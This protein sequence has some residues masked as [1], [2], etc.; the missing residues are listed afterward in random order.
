MNKPKPEEYNPYFKPYIQIV[1][2]GNF[3]DLLKQNTLE[4]ADFFKSITA[5]K[6]NFAYMHGKWTIK[7]VLMHLI[8]V[9]RVMCYRTLVAARGDKDTVLYPFDEDAYQINSGGSLRTM[10]SLIEEFVT[11]RKST[12]VFFETITE[13]QS[14]FQATG[15][16]H[17]FTARALGYIIL[18]HA[19]HHVNMVKERYL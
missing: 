9:E 13:T 11:L 8:D 2:A 7:E 18:G 14:T 4:V 12:E 5:G 6:H 17:P 3:D 1:P 10:P 19:K 15:V 16:T